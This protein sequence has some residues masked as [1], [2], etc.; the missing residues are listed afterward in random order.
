VTIE[1]PYINIIPPKVTEIRAE[2]TQVELEVV[3]SEPVQKGSAETP[4]NYVIATPGAPDVTA[5]TARLLDDASTV[6]LRVPAL[7]N[8][9]DYTLKVIGI[10]DRATPPNKIAAGTAVKFTYAGKPITEPPTL[11]DVPQVRGD[12]LRLTVVFN[13]ALDLSTAVAADHYRLDDPVI[14]VAQVI[15]KPGD[16]KTVFLQLDQPLQETKRYRLTVSGLADF[17]GN[18][19]PATGYTSKPFDGPGIS[20]VPTDV[21]GIAD[22]KTSDDG[23]MLT[24]NFTEEVDRASAIKLEN[25]SLG[26]NVKIEKVG[27]D[28]VSFRQVTLKLVERLEARRYTLVVRN[29]GLR[30]DPSRVQREITQSIGGPGAPFG[31]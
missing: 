19:I 25:Y 13:E 28:E 1:F 22:F 12:G 14:K 21:I 15:P 29:I 9:K 27:F 16:A 18:V 31:H 11:V 26:G 2:R 30:S 6:Q 10:E 24:F 7:A 8:G 5:S 20:I 17:V 3:F 4:G 23:S